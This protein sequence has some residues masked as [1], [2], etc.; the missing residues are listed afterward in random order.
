MVIKQIKRKKGSRKSI[1]LHVIN[2]IEYV[3][4][5][6]EPGNDEKVTLRGSINVESTELE[7]VIAEFYA[8]ASMTVNSEN[9]L[10]HWVASIQAGEEF[11]QETAEEV[12]RTFLRFEGWEGCQTFWAV[13]GN[14]D[15]WHL[16]IIVNR[17][18]P[19]MGKCRSKDF[20]HEKAHKAAADLCA[21]LG[22]RPEPRARYVADENGIKRAIH[23]DAP[24]Q[25][26]DGARASEIH[27]GV[28]SAFR[29]A[30]EIAVP[31][32]TSAK[33]WDELHDRLAAAGFQ[34][35]RKGGGAVLRA[36]IGE[37]VTEVKPSSLN[38]A[39]SLKK[40]E[41][42][43]GAYA[44]PGEGIRVKPRKP[45]PVDGVPAELL[46]R[47]KEELRHGEAEAAK[48]HTAEDAVPVLK[49]SKSWT[50]VH[51]KL[52]AIGAE[53]RKK[54]GGAVLVVGGTEVK[55]SSLGKNYSMAKMEKRLG[56]FEEKAE[57]VVVAEREPAA[58]VGEVMEWKKKA[59]GQADALD[60]D[61]P[62]GEAIRLAIDGLAEERLKDARRKKALRSGRR[63]IDFD[64]WL[65][66]KSPRAEEIIE[67]MRGSRAVEVDPCVPEEEVRA[68]VREFETLDREMGAERYALAL[69]DAAAGIFTAERVIE[70]MPRIMRLEEDRGEMMLVTRVARPELVTRASAD[71]MRIFRHGAAR[72]EAAQMARDMDAYRALRVRAMRA[73][74]ADADREIAEW[75]LAA[76]HSPEGI[77]RIFKAAGRPSPDV[78]KPAKQDASVWRLL[79]AARAWL[80]RDKYV[81]VNTEEQT[82]KL[83]G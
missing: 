29:V 63:A 11:T 14:T 20:S 41:K 6:D 32:L 46:K 44:E 68:R 17:M 5:N 35:V 52:A 58:E 73:G 50:E 36:H 26:P 67:A 48:A 55:P 31:I 78:R 34:Y 80:Y 19:M 45:E 62:V 61:G 81:E 43:L 33:G 69:G 18:D 53:Y 38:K 74:V 59:L 37:D 75:L 76:G 25:I 39:L 70:L 49:E 8:V 23:L 12:V 10:Q 77:E 54:G 79:R 64:Q 51:E 2:M 16:H 9:P 15:H 56:P 24:A 82:L 21:R 27:S 30:A 72:W 60:V 4:G 47:Y 71:D 83:G 7:D 28:K 42:K 3:N 1:H 22:F 40:M 65:R 13:H 57:S 66:A